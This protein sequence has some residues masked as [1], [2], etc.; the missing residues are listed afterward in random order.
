MRCP[1]CRHKTEVLETRDTYRRRRCLNP[2]CRRVFL[3]EETPLPDKPITTPSNRTLTTRP[4]L[5]P[6]EPRHAR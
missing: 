4:P 1:A 5:Q 3:S 2:A 6:A